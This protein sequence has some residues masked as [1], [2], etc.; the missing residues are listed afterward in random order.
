MQDTYLHRKLQLI[1]QLRDQ[2]IVTQ[3]L[4]HLHYSDNSSVDLVLPILKYSL[5]SANLFFNL[6]TKRKKYAD[7]FFMILSLMRDSVSG[8]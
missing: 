5:C 1:V 8:I 4:S 3:R 2:E 6:Y 7:V